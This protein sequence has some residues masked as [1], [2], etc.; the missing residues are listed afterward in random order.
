[1]GSAPSGARRLFRRAVAD[2]AALFRGRR[3]FWLVVVERHAVAAGALDSIHGDVGVLEDLVGGGAFAVEHDDAEAGRGAVVERAEAETLAHRRQD[4]V[5][6]EDGGARRARPVAPGLA[7][8]DD[9]L[10]AA[11]ARR[12]VGGRDAGPEPA[13]D[14][15]EKGV[16]DVVAVRVVQQ[17]EIVEIDEDQRARSRAGAA[18]GEG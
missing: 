17:L 12:R 11:D 9:E 13:G 4:L 14:L 16:A 7:E 15:D 8:D 6:G 2:A 5:A 1:S 3:R 18:A 10:V